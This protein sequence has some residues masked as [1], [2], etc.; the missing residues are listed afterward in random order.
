MASVIKEIRRD[1]STPQDTSAQ[2]KSV[3]WGGG[4]CGSLSKFIKK[5]SYD[6]K[7][8]GNHVL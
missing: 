4:A 7:L 2:W 3:Y 5:K 8:P 1:M 6:M